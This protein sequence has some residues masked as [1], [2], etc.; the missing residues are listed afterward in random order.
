MQIQRETLSSL[1]RSAGL[2][3]SLYM[4][5]VGDKV[6]VV[7]DILEDNELISRLST[8]QYEPTKSY[9]EATRL[10][11]LLVSNASIVISDIGGTPH[12]K[13]AVTSHLCQSL[14]DLAVSQNA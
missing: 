10:V 1:A 13:Q 12:T 9:D 4:H 8:L 3:V 6:F 5:E 11:P 2:G 7:C 14:E